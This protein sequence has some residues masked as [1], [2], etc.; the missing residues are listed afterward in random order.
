M[1]RKALGY[2]IS[3]TRT[4]VVRPWIFSYKYGKVLGRNRVLKTSELGRRC[5]ILG[6]G[7]S[8]SDQDILRFRNEETFIV[9]NFW[10]HPDYRELNPKYY[11]VT[12]PTFFPS[13]EG[14]K[15]DTIEDMM[16]R[17]GIVSSLPTKLFYNVKGEKFIQ[18]NK[19]FP[20][21]EIYYICQNGFFK[22][23][24]NFNVEI[25]KVI[26]EVKNV[27]LG[28]LMI[29]GYMGFEEIY[30][31]GCEH[32]FLAHPSFYEGFKHFYEEKKYDLADKKEVAYYNLNVKSYED[33]IEFYRLT[34]RNYR[35]FKEKIAKTH[36][37]VKIYNATPESFLDVFPF[38][39]YED[40]KI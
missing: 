25:D 12:D 21:N 40:V 37:N 38:V 20:N 7:P 17:N 5:F 6:T 31:L 11:V 22:S 14:E 4:N 30:L 28:A 13:F 19:L 35:L 27:V 23:D 16:R 36:P 10:K 8:I 15:T 18:K 24:L 39:K 9:N 26:P 2:L 34:F 1:I 29:A 32:D 3:Y 33:V